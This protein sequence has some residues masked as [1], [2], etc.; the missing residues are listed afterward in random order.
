MH[1]V[2]SSQRNEIGGLAKDRLRSRMAALIFSRD[3]CCLISKGADP[4]EVGSTREESKS[5]NLTVA[6]RNFIPS[7]IELIE[8]RTT[9]NVQRTSG[10]HLQPRS[11]HI[12]IRNPRAIF[13]LNL[14]LTA[15]RRSP[16]H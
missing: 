16:F 6:T 5:N 15:Q 14:F 13:S 4:D 12:E 2:V 9:I 1:L 7:T 11:Q 3:D 10:R 8:N